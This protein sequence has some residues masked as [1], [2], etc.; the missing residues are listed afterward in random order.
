MLPMIEVSF[1]EDSNGGF[2]KL[3]TFTLPKMEK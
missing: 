1:L 3:K 2:M